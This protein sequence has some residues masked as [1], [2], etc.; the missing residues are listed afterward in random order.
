VL[1]LPSIAI[2]ITDADAHTTEYLRQNGGAATAPTAAVSAAGATE[3]SVQQVFVCNITAGT[4]ITDSAS[5]AT[6]TGADIITT[7]LRSTATS[8][9]KS[10][11]FKYLES[12][13]VACNCQ[14]VDIMRTFT[15]NCAEQLCSVVH[16]HW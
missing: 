16:A 11:S 12:C 9:H 6:V 4:G 15:S 7:H 2:V 5:T 8:C 3:V 14:R 10:H 13:A 1:T